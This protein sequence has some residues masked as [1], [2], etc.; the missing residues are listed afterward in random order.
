MIINRILQSIKKILTSRVFYIGIVFG[1]LLLVPVF[2]LYN[3]QI[4]KGAE[5]AEKKEYYTV[6]E[7]YIP[8]TRGNIY[9]KNG[10]L[11]AYNE[12]SYSVF[13]EDTAVLTTNA[14]KNEM[15]VQLYKLLRAH[16]Y[17]PEIEFAIYLDENNVP[18]FNV[19][20]NAELR[21]KKNAYG[22][23]SVNR[24][25]NEQKN[26]TAAEVF[27]FLAH[28]NKSAAMFQGLFSLCSSS[29]RIFVFKCLTSVTPA[30]ITD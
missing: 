2:R 5:V 29:G 4:V 11:L 25:T 17:E 30:S 15:I 8:A 21:F 26:A 19:S 16:G 18:Q 24:L 13:L 1:A 10:V 12:L 28:G 20:G 22:L 14:Q 9:D 7:R 27:D 3:L 23:T 6:K